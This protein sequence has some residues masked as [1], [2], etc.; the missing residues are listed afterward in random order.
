MTA[1]PPSPWLLAGLALLSGGLLALCF[2]PFGLYPLAWVALVPLFAALARAHRPRQGAW[3]GFLTG[4]VFFGLLHRYLLMYGVLPTVLVAAFQALPVVLFGWV[5]VRVSRGPGALRQAAGLAGAWVLAE[6]L[7]GNLGGLSLTMGQL[8]YSQQPALPL[9]QTASVA[10]ALGISFLLALVN[11]AL[12]GALFPTDRRLRGRWATAGLVGLLVATAWGWGTL[13]LRQPLPAGSTLRVGVVQ[14]NVFL[15][16]PVTLEDA[17]ESLKQYP[18]YT[19]LLMAPYGSPE[20]AHPDRPQLVVWPETALPVTLN[21]EPAF[22][23]AARET[24][25]RHRIWLLMGALEVQPPAE[26]YASDPNEYRRQV[27]RRPWW[28]SEEAY[29][30]Q[31]RLYNTAWLFDPEG[32]LRGTYSKMDLVP[33]GEYVPFRDRL[34]LLDRYPVRDFDF[35]PGTERNLLSVEAINC[36]ALICFEAILPQGSREVA[37]SG[38]GFLAFL[39]SDAWA[40]P[41]H[42]VLVHSQTAPLRAV[43][44]GRWVVRAASIGRSAIISPRGK[45]VDQVKPLRSGVGHGEIAALTGLTPYVRYGDTP[46][47]VVSGLVVLI[48]LGLWWR[49]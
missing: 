4:L 35:M 22:E 41:S 49:R 11:A 6:W 17:Q 33:F 45:I 16:T 30:T 27:A 10:G 42:E 15:H 21:Q 36:G 40:G 25:R 1:A 47:L 34:P 28:Q 46:L 2:P 8:G 3:L 44:T 20:A 43:E 19:G 12:A 5:G 7:R 38:A 24:A 23:E 29:L 13:V 37:R 26:I 48:G 32:K 31:S 39:T 9:L 18:R 14:P